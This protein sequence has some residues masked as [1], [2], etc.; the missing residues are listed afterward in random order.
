MLERAGDEVAVASSI[1][2]YAPGSAFP[3][4]MH[5]LGEEFLVLE[6]VFSD[7]DGDYETGTYVRNPPGS[8]HAPFSREGCVIFVKLRQ[9]RAQDIGRVRVHAGDR[10]WTEG[11]SPGHERAVLHADGDISVC[12]ERAAPGVRV[13]EFSRP[14]GQEI[15]V[16]NGTLQV[17]EPRRPVLEVWSW[18]REPGERQSGFV[19]ETG[20]LWWVKRGH[21]P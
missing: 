21:L 5:G 18:L 16:L 15:F 12:L 3:P 8:R 2:R 11:E 6:G 14:G 4:H 10:R 7:E 9:M 13:P 20:A 1:V 17:L 19:S